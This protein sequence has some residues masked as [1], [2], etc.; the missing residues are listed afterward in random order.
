MSERC[1]VCDSLLE[2]EKN[3]STRRD[4]Y[5]F[6]CPRCGEYEISRPLLVSLPAICERDPDAAAKIS[7]AIRMMGQ[8]GRETVLTT[9]DVDEILKKPLPTPK[10]QADIFLRWLAENVRGPGETLVVKHTTHMSIMGARTPDGFAFV[11]DHLFD[12]GLLAGYRSNEVGAGALVHAHA[13][14]SFKGWEWYDRLKRGS[15]S[16][17]KAFIAMQFNDQELDRINE[18]VYKPCIKATGFKP[19]RL[20]DTPS[21]GLIDDRLRVELQSA[22]FVIADLSHD[23]PGAYWEAGY[24]EGLGKPVI[25]ACGKTEFECKKTHF[26]TN[27]HL[28][29]IWDIENIEDAKKKL[30]ATIRATLPHL[31]TCE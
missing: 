10:E 22:D 2:K 12:E 17:R 20:D 28:T 11:L 4:A 14:P 7:H 27:H 23:N 24:A 1:P 6:S 19:V 31:A 8:N 5:C 18:E 13:T 9:Y 25:Y 16:Y 30:V 15:G 21:A 26:D 3:S 29:I